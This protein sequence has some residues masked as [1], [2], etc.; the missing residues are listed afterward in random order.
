MSQQDQSLTNEVSP[1]NDTPS[2]IRS[3][4]LT[5]GEIRERAN[6]L[7][8]MAQQLHDQYVENAR[9]E[10]SVI[11]ETAKMEA[12]QTVQEAE[13]RASS[14]VRDAQVLA[15]QTL[16]DLE[17]RKQ[18]LLAEII[19]LQ[20]FEVEY[21]TKLFE[22]V[23]SASETLSVGRDSEGIASEGD[24]VE[25]ADVSDAPDLD[26]PRGNSVEEVESE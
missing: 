17:R 9:Q 23:T 11:E 4:D 26:V 19:K 8:S 5:E 13:S 24:V 22:L 3:V 7:L 14:I 12:S 1:K 20:S 6:D 2:E 16:D 10:A 18:G 15:E 25:G 21:R